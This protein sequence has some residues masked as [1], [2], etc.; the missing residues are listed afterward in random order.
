MMSSRLLTDDTSNFASFGSEP[1]FASMI[2]DWD[3]R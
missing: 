2:T 3:S 1:L